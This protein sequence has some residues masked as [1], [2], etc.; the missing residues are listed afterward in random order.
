MISKCNTCQKEVVKFTNV[1]LS[2]CDECSRQYCLKKRLNKLSGYVILAEIKIEY[3]QY[4][5]GLYLQYINRYYLKYQILKQADDLLSY[6]KENQ[7]ASFTNW[8]KIHNESTLFRQ[9]H[10]V[11]NGVTG[12]PFI[13]IGKMLA[14]L[15]VLSQ[16]IEDFSQY[17]IKTLA[18]FPLDKLETI[19]QF[20]DFEKTKNILD[21]SIIIRLEFIL[22]FQ[23]WITVDIYL[24][25]PLDIQN[26]FI[27]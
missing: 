22:Y 19:K 21:K 9:Q 23:Q 5:F 17:Y 10:K 26:Y 20:I 16:K 11:I 7:V 18:R 15:G 13:K 8:E 3:N 6:L 4:L 14:E 25:T 1:K 27:H 12:C 2:L 24:V